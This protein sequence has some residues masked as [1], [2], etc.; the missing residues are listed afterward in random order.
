MTKDSKRNN[1]FKR[2]KGKRVREKTKS[3]GYSGIAIL[4]VITMLS[5]AM[6]VYRIKTVTSSKEDSE[7]NSNS[8]ITTDATADE[9]LADTITVPTTAPNTVPST[10]VNTIN[11]T[12]DSARIYPVDQNEDSE[13]V[14]DHKEASNVSEENAPADP[15]NAP[16][17]NAPVD[18]TN[19]PEENAPANPT[20][21]P[22]KEMPAEP[23]NV[24]DEDMTIE[25]SNVL[26]ED[27][28]VKPSDTPEAIEPYFNYTADDV[29]LLGDLMYAEEGV[30]IYLSEYTDQ[31]NYEEAKE[32]H[33]LCGSVL[34]HLLELGICGDDMQSIIFTGNAYAQITRDRILSGQLEVPQEVYEWAE[35][36]LRD[37]PIGPKNLVFQAEFIQ[38]PIYRHIYNQYFCTSEYFP[39]E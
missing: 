19:T 21:A 20:N 27:V 13:N 4:L 15:T 24:P 38:G 18:P 26:E 17:E 14:R 5:T 12:D 31:I 33:K 3:K 6:M 1:R 32:A 2:Y 25:P 7:N 37:G 16:E 30:L 23:T 10:N 29:K 36:L 39:A 28:P 35:E 22:E 9:S 8:T 11:N 34:L